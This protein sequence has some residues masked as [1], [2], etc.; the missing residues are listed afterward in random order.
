MSLRGRILAPVTRW[1]GRLLV[2]DDL[3][4]GERVLCSEAEKDPRGN[5]WTA[6]NTHLHLTPHASRVNK[7]RQGELFTY[8]IPYSAV[9]DFQEARLPNGCIRRTISYEVPGHAGE[10]ESLSGLFEPGTVKQG[11]LSST[12]REL[13]PPR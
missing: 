10:E 4:P 13:I 12:L 5:T 3:N 11:Y 8:V 1:A 7:R 6:T 2:S 9:T